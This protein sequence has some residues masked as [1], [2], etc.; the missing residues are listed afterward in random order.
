MPCGRQEAF[1][2]RLALVLG[3][4]DH[5]GDPAFLDAEGLSGFSRK[6]DDAPAVVGTAIVYD[7]FD[8]AAVFH[9]CYP[10]Q[11]FEG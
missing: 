1:G 3:A 11:G 2:C 10:C 6:V 5:F 9:I 7:N 8:R 4:D